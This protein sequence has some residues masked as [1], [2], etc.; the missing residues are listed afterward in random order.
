MKNLNLAFSKIK[1]SENLLNF[2]SLCKKEN[3]KIVFTNG[4]FDVL[5]YG[6]IDYLSKAADLGTK[7]IIGLNSDKSVKR[8]KGDSR[9]VNDQKSRAMVLASLFFVDAVIIFEE[10]TPEMLVKSISPDIMVKGGDY[11]IEN[12]AG[13]DFV[14]ANGGSIEIIPFVEGFSSTNIINL[15]GTD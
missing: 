2:I 1:E 6:H 9:P 12:I 13:A 11:K 3:D 14:I 10:D 8:L 4:C 15:I 7:L 5:H